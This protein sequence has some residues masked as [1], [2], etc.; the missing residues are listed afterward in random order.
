MKI[1]NLLVYLVTLTGGVGLFLLTASWMG[2][3]IRGEAEKRDGSS[4]DHAAAYLLYLRS[5]QVTGSVDMKDVLQARMDAARLTGNSTRGLNIQWTELGPDNYGGRTRSIIV[6]NRD[7][8]GK[9]IYAASVSGGIWKSTNSGQTWARINGFEENPNIVTMV[10]A[11]NGDIYAGTGEYFIAPDDRISRFSGFIGRGIYLC[12]D[13]DNFQVLPSTV[14]VVS[15]GTTSLWAYVNKLAI[16]PNTGRIYAAVNGGLIYSDNGFDTFTFAQT[17]TGDLLDTI[18]TDVD[19]ASNGMVAAVVGMH[20][21]VSPTGSPSGFV[22]QSIRYYSAPDT[23]VNENKLPMA[24]IAR[25]ELAIAPS[26]NDVIYAMTAS[27]QDA[28]HQLEFG[29]LEG[30]YLSEDKGENWMIIGPG[31]S[32]QF[33]VMGDGTDYYG[34]YNN[35][36]AVHPTDPYTILAGGVDMWE[37]EKVNTTGFYNWIK[38]SSSLEGVST[39]IHSSHHVYVFNPANPSVCY[40]GSDGGMFITDDNF[41]SFRSINRQYNTS[42]FYSVGFDSKGYPIGG[43]QGNG[44]VYLDHQGNTPENGSQ[45]GW[46]ATSMNGGYQEISMIMPSCFILSGEALNL[47]RSDDYGRNFSPVFIPASITNANSFLTPFAL[48]ESFNNQNSRDSVTFIAERDY[49]AGDTAMIP[50]ANNGVLFPYV[51]PSWINQ[52]E[53]VTVKDIVSARFFLAVNNAVYMTSQVLD[54]TI[55]PTFY[56]IATIQGNPLCIACSGDANYVYV[57]TDGGNIY[58]IANLALA[59]NTETADISSNA[60]IVATSLVASYTGRAVTSVAV[61]PNN[62]DHMVVTLGNY[63]NTDYVYRSINAMDSLPTFVSIQGNLPKMP[64]YSSLIELNSSDRIILGSELGIWSTD[65]AGTSTL[66]VNDNE[67]MGNVPVFMLKQQ[68]LAQYPIANYGV[69]YAATHGRG[70]FQ[71]VDFVGINDFDQPATAVLESLHLYPN[72]ASDVIRI[73]LSLERRADVSL[74]IVDLNGQ[75][76]KDIVHLSQVTAG[77]QEIQC[78]LDNLKSGTYLLIVTSDG[79]R[80]TSK[81]IIMR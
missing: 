73:T 67:G 8:T 81:F 41:N 78:K 72:P 34:F 35:T 3:H 68:R 13:G 1:R 20:C 32:N 52:G 63:G 57:G 46:A 80:K 61:D 70:I 64:V 53:E 43:T 16:D 31:G 7:A 17:G 21:Y 25:L 11:S 26:N 59:Y 45:L 58:R 76:V 9:T 14:P 10:Q 62:P 18:A 28:V 12:T 15:E 75:K 19:V 40:I 6:D 69:M 23:I 77:K 51:V 4:V 29:E 54:F 48:W 71:S 60:C 37:G 55:E 44:I 33:N 22:D 24:N 47:F 38:K 56:K 65:N 39:Y 50:S 36:L 49:G 42:Q 5:N 27:S 66:W 74:E 30:I 2:Y 79:Q